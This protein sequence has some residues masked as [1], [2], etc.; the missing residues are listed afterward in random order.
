MTRND[1]LDELNKLPAEERLSIVETALHQLREQ[2][3]SGKG[4]ASDDRRERLCVAADA[5][6]GAYESDRELTAFTTLDRDDYHAS[7]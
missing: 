1:I 4:D 6:K 3:R 2:F 7:R 5:L